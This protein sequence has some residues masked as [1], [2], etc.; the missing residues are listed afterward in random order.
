MPSSQEPLIL[1]AHG[2]GGDRT[3]RL[4]RDL[5]LSKFA[6][7]ILEQMDDSASLTLP[8]TDVIFTTD[9]YVVNPLFFSGGD[10]GKLAACGTI[11][12]LAMQGARPLHLS[13]GL[14]LE[15]GLAVS[16]LNKILD[17]LA[18][19]ITSLGVT[20]VTGDT[21]VVQRGHG[22][23]CYINTTGLGQRLPGVNVHVSNA[24]PGDKIILTG[25]MGDHGMAI[26]CQRE[27]LKLSSPLLSDTA[28]L[29]PMIESLL[30]AIPEI[31]VLRDPTRGGV[32]GALNDIARASRCG[33]TIMESRL[34]VRP[35]VRGA[36]SLLGLDPLTI[37][38]EGKA[39]V[40]CPADKAR[41][42]LEVIQSTPLGRDAALIGEVVADHPDR[43][44]LQTALS[45]KRLV[46]YPSGEDLPRIC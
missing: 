11:N 43:V 45:S 30:N 39:I 5:I 14:I 17:S 10:I 29:W 3:N 20:L 9:S 2:G 42:A 1:L 44:F 36:S 18:G 6:N 26:M 16:D 19:V 33:I 4:I 41:A 35:E 34:P 7:P 32:A 8:S 40:I 27:G 28:P 13:M 46:D 12:D 38:N 21:K 31:S 15:E 37:A 22:H 23:G 25:T 24:K